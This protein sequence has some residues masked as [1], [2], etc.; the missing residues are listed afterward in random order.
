MSIAPLYPT[1]RATLL[2][3]MLALNR[4]S[5]AADKLPV[6]ASFSILGDITSQIGGDR[7]ALTTLVGPN[8]DA[9]VYQP[10]PSDAQYVGKARVLIFNGLGMEGWL[11]RLI[12]A[13]QFKGKIVIASTGITTRTMQDE[14]HTTTDPH[15]WQNPQNVIQYTRN[16][17]AALSAAD[18]AGKAYY[19]QRAALYT[20]KLQELD[21]WAKQ[22][23]NLLPASKRQ[24]ITSHDAFAYLG[25]H[26]QIKFFAPQGMSTES[27]AAGGDVGKLIRQIKQTKIR[28]LFFESIS[29]RK[30]L[31]Q[32]AAETGV[33]PGP[34]LYS[35]ALSPPKGPAN[36]YEMLFQHNINTLL[37]GMQQN[38]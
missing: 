20:Q 23:I 2:F 30:L 12:T 8:G 5:L 33:T 1:L 25:E 13:A 32:I 34:A 3:L 27:E 4:N 19:Q 21:I 9:H 29:S 24:V 11:P 17:S 15:A 18:P 35:D 38:Q 36:T 28:A 26:Y 16:I 22:R 31:D 6:V 10:T 37:T 7:I 14:G